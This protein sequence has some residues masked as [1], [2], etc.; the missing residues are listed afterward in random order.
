MYTCIIH[1]DNSNYALAQQGNID[2][3]LRAR[4]AMLISLKFNNRKQRNIV[5]TCVC[6][7]VYDKTITKFQFG[8]KSTAICRKQLQRDAQC[9]TESTLR[10]RCPH[11]RGPHTKG[12]V[13][14]HCILFVE[15]LDCPFGSYRI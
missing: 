4:Y 1:T 10:T 12:S 5:C 9:R 3:K 2:Y 13:K 7:C 6:N 15:R 8:Y 14:V 11:S